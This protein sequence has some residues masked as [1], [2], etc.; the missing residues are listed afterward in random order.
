MMQRKVTK[1]REALCS[2]LADIQKGLVVVVFDGKPGE[3]AT[4]TELE[5]GMR[6]VITAGGDTETGA[7]RVTADEWILQDMR[8][9]ES[10]R[11]EVVTADKELR[12]LASSVRTTVKL[13]NPV[14]WWRRYLP[15]LKGLKNDYSNTPATEER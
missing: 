11:I 2:K 6:M 4:H 9:A 8:N 7:V 12:R 15:R 14:K 3:P 5:G 13:I 10:S 1:G